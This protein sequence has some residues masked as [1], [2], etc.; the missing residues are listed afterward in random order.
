MNHPLSP[1]IT[2]TVFNKAGQEDDNGRWQTED[3]P[4]FPRPL[5]VALP[6][7]R[8]DRQTSV[9]TGLGNK[10]DS[11]RARRVSLPKTA[12]TPITLLPPQRPMRQQS[13]VRG[14]SIASS[15]TESNHTFMHRLDEET[16][17]EET[18]DEETIDEESDE[19]EDEEEFV[20]NNQ[21]NESLRL[22]AL[23]TS[24]SRMEGSSRDLSPMRP[25]RQK[26]VGIDQ[27][28]NGSCHER[29]PYSTGSQPE[30]VKLWE[31][32]GGNSGNSNSLN[33][34]WKFEE[35]EDEE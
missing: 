25:T 33:N 9:A 23:D 7:K 10:C 13:M 1:E 2:I 24:E 14:V 32:Q 34:L 22:D 18:I 16:I 6:P 20:L 27:L 35:D 17:D 4:C 15:L 19:E 5:C 21:F 30:W 8:P 11:P 29:K 31:S 3:S 12:K 28:T 26:S